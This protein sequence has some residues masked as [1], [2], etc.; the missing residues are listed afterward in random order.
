VREFQKTSLIIHDEWYV[1]LSSDE[2]SPATRGLPRKKDAVVV[3]G[4][5]TPD[6]VWQLALRFRGYRRLFSHRTYKLRL[7]MWIVGD[8][9]PV[10]VLGV[11]GGFPR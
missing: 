6:D 11:D 7:R 8:V 2:G 10:R 5:S 4:S 3:W 9:E 1:D